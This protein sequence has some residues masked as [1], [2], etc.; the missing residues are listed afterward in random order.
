MIKEFNSLEEIQKYYNR[1]TN[2]YVFKED[3]A[4]IDLIV[5]TF[6]LNVQAKIVAWNIKAC[7]IRTNDIIANDIN[8]FNI[9]AKDIIAADINARNIVADYIVAKDI[10]ANDII[11]IDICYFALCFAYK[12]IKCSKSIKGRMK[13]A[14]HLVLDGKIEVEKNDVN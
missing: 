13:N 7:N 4:Y 12:N 2:T 14:K 9:N 11:A 3:E 1:N 5:F 10:I 6:D 8:A